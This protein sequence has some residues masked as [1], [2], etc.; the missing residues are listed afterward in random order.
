MSKPQDQDQGHTHEDG[1]FDF[2]PALDMAVWVSV[3][4]IAALVIE[5]VAGRVIRERLASQ[6]G[7]Y[8]QRT[9]LSADPPQ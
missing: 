5:W 7:R 8:L 9:G 3:G 1:G 2:W 4:I 6:A